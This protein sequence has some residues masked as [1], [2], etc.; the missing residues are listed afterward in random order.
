MVTVKSQ[1]KT[2]FVQIF[3]LTAFLYGFSA[4]AA[5][6]KMSGCIDFSAS[7]IQKTQECKIL[8]LRSAMC[9]LS[10]NCV[11]YD[12][13]TKILDY[14]GELF[15]L[16]KQELENADHKGEIS[17]RAEL[18][19][20]KMFQIASILSTSSQTRFIEQISAVNRAL[21][22][23]FGW[24]KCSNQ[25]MLFF[26]KKSCFFNCVKQWIEGPVGRLAKVVGG[27]LVCVKLVDFLKNPSE[28]LGGKDRK[29]IQKKLGE[30]VNELKRRSGYL[31][32]KNR[33]LRQM[34]AC[35]E[36]ELKEMKDASRNFRQES[37]ALRANYEG[38]AGE[39][40]KIGQ[41]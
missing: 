36:V 28:N 26:F 32:D 24:N 7:G 2:K 8:T 12:F 27:F 39:L 31:E 14:L 29:K 40:A 23:I 9:D 19:K 38:I 20:A 6:V 35:H 17:N 11:E 22:P 21:E 18:A 13:Y 4:Q 25:G 16:S 3:R 37:E 30:E 33:H 34:I 5:D 10:K 41:R 1:V 15:C